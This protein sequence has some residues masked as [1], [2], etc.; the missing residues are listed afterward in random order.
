MLQIKLRIANI[1]WLSFWHQVVEKW[2]TLFKD[3][4]ERKEESADRKFRNYGIIS[5]FLL[6]SDNPCHTIIS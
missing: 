1:S 2:L 5:S 3:V 6:P 4:P